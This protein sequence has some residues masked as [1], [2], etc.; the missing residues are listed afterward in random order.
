MMAVHDR[1][2]EIRRRRSAWIE[3]IRP[4]A[5][6]NGGRC[7]LYHWRDRGPLGSAGAGAD[8]SL[9]GRPGALNAAG[10]VICAFR[11]AFD[12][13]LVHGGINRV[14]APRRGW[15]CGGETNDERGCD[16]GDI[17]VS[18]HRIRSLAW[19]SVFPF[20]RTIR[21]PGSG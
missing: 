5:A 19:I 20:R 15:G 21:L 4:E 18:F 14:F 6:T 12:D 17:L 3:Q 8:D 9:A 1:D 11:F 10:L 13:V 16:Q 7:Y 2:D